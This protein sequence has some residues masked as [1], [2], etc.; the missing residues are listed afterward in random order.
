M[1]DTYVATSLSPWELLLHF[2]LNRQENGRRFD[3]N[4]KGQSD[5]DVAVAFDLEDPK[6][7]KQAALDPKQAVL[8]A[9]FGRRSRGRFCDIQY[10]PSQVS[11]RFQLEQY[12]FL[13]S[14]RQQLERDINVVVAY[15]RRTHGNGMLFERRFSVE[16]PQ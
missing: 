3:E 2:I 16:W 9:F 4:G 10:A 7:P 8:A 5:L 14:W 1:Q 12:G 15:S 11:K 13:F 6:D